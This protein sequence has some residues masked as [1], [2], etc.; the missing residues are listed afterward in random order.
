MP[1]QEET[2]AVGEVARRAGVTTATVNF[3][4]REGLLPKPEKTART[5]ALY[6]ASSVAR[7][8]RIRSLQA[9]SLPL[10]LIRRVLTSADPLAALGLEPGTEPPARQRA[11][12]RVAGMDAFLRETGLDEAAFAELVERGL[13]QSGGSTAG[14]GEPAF[15]R[16]DVAGGRAFAGL[17]ASGVSMRLLARHTEYEPLSRAEAHFLAEHLASARRR[18]A[19][20]RVSASFVAAAFGVVRD[21]L[22]LRQLDSAYA[23]W[24]AQ[25]GDRAGHT[26]PG[27]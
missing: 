14:A 13:L 15:N 3:Y 11:L 9:Q 19:P 17:L 6:P 5:R 23:D 22:R 27:Q 4:V 26:T 24:S 18:G 8:K 10:R 7:I 12:A 25:P 16:Q 21:Y 2:M 1:D 20:G